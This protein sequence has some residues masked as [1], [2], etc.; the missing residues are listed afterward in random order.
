VSAPARRLAASPYARRLARE[1]GMDLSDMVGTGPGGRIVAADVPRPRAAAPSPAPAAPIPPGPSPVPSPTPLVQ[2]G[3]F[4]CRI[5]LTALH[6]LLGAIGAAGKE[7]TFDDLLIKAAATA[8]AAR[9]A[10]SGSVLWITPDAAPVLISGAERLPLSAVAAQCLRGGP[11]PP[12]HAFA[13]SRV[14]PTGLRPLAVAIPE[15]CVAHLV[16]ALDTAT[17]TAEALLQYSTAAITLAEAAAVLA[18]IRDG[19]EKPLR[20]LV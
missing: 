19:L 15:G 13:V 8:D 20:L 3:A 7:T 10:S 2:T 5:H 1:R 12:M 16:V 6:A 14:R 18:V 11:A 17:T 9:T 4:A